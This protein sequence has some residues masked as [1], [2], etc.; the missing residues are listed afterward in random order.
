MKEEIK[1][2]SEKQ[3]NDKDFTNEQ[4]IDLLRK[5]FGCSLL[6]ATEIMRRNL[7]KLKQ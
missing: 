7:E 1:P 6:Y 4:I 5:S 3:M 2:L